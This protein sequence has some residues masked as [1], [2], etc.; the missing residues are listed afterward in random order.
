MDVSE[1]ARFH[2][3]R[4][5]IPRLQKKDIKG[6]GIW[7]NMMQ[8][9]KNPKDNHQSNHTYNQQDGDNFNFQDEKYQDE[10]QPEMSNLSNFEEDNYRDQQEFYILNIQHINCN[11]NRSID[12]SGSKQDLLFDTNF[13]T[14][15]K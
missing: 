7:K 10:D 15:G 9:W 5:G 12:L 13:S 8:A 14:K 3:T 11:K 1:A 4:Y 2:N 6:G